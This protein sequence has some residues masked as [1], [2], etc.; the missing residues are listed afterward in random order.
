[1]NG[2]GPF[3]FLLDTGATLTCVDESLARELDLPQATGV[4][5]FGGTVEGFGAMRLLQLDAVALGDAA[6]HNLRGC[7]LNLAPMN[8]RVSTFEVSCA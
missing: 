4:V 7:A 6:V 1:V 2:A 8:K 3:R 5:G